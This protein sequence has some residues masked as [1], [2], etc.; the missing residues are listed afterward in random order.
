M[1][2]STLTTDEL[3]VRT[4]LIPLYT[5]L[6]TLYTS[7]LSPNHLSIPTSRPPPNQPP[8]EYQH[9]CWELVVHAAGDIASGDPAADFA[10]R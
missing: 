2:I 1:W 4:E 10:W 8:R 9:H 5:Y 3:T 6:I 7:L